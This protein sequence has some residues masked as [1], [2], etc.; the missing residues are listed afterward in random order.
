MVLAGQNRTPSK[1][2]Y[3]A[4]FSTTNPTWTDLGAKPDLR[5]AKAATYHQSYGTALAYITGVTTTLL[6]SRTWLAQDTFKNVRVLRTE[7]FI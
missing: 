2:R 7:Y 6:A 3:E 4:T 1:T 5:G